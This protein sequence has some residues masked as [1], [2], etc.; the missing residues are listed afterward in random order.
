MTDYKSVQHRE[1]APT[2]YT[3]REVLAEAFVDED[4]NFDPD[5][6]DSL[7]NSREQVCETDAEN[8]VVAPQ[9]FLSP[10]AER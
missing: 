8:T 4:D 6:R 5:V 3:L 7:S 9:I 2:I 1:Q 10:T